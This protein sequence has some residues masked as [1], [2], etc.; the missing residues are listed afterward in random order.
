MAH[1]S[2]SFPDSK[3][4][5]HYVVQAGVELLGSRNLLASTSPNAGI[6]GTECD[7]PQRDAERREGALESAQQTRVKMLPPLLPSYVASGIRVEGSRSA[8]IGAQGL[9]EEAIA[10]AGAGNWMEPEKSTDLLD[11]ITGTHHQAQPV[12]VFLAE[13]HFPHAGQAGHELL[14]SGN[15][16]ASASQ[17]AWI[18]GQATPIYKQKESFIPLWLNDDSVAD[19]LWRRELCK[20]RGQTLGG[21][22]WTPEEEG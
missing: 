11:R 20:E 21:A 8:M 22:L 10:T 9:G 12:F 2:L 6:T 13:T 18:V 17:R 14:T 3:T 7:T 15:P 1:C 19:D 16:P 4:E 5:S